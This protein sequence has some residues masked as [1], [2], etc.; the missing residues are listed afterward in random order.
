MEESFVV[1]GGCASVLRQTGT[2]PPRQEG[3]AVGLDAKLQALSQ[4]FEM[5]S[6]QTPIGHPLCLDCEAQLKE[7]VEVQV[8]K[9]S[10]LFKK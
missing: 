5:A 4:L 8:I 1:L 7:E 2:A 6:L 10:A 3:T 9:L